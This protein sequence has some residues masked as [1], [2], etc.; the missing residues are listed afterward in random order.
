MDTYS[1]IPQSTFSQKITGFLEG[2]PIIYQFLR[3]A[4]I[5]LLNTAL[6][7]LLLNTIAKAVGVSQG[8]KYGAIDIFSF[9]VAIVQSYIWNRTWTFG[10]EQG[11]TLLKNFLRLVLVGSLGAVSII[12]VLVGSKFFAPAPYYF[13]IT[14]VYLILE[15]VL[16]RGFG[17]HLSDWH[18]QGHSFFIFATV[19]F[20]GLAINVFLV[21]VLSLHIHITHT[22]LDQNIAKILATCISLFWNFTGYKVVV[23]KK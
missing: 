9:S 18:H 13:S 6:D 12:F 4:C 21:S 8:W 23:F 19:T 3:F 7:F 2:S 15:S 10:S 16:W 11:V 14:I 5:G 20:I 22:D 1:A 17:F